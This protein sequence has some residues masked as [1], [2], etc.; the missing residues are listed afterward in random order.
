MNRPHTRNTC[1]ERIFNE[2]SIFDAIMQKTIL[3]HGALGS[4]SDLTPLA[5]ALLRR[6][7][8]PL[9]F[10]FSGHGKTPFS[11][12]FEITQFCTELENFISM[13]DLRPATI[14]GYSM[15]GYVALCS[16]LRNTEQI[17]RV[18]T[19]GTKFDWS[20][21]SVAKE[22]R[23]LDPELT[24]QKV[25]AFAAMLHQKHGDNW[26][27]LMRATAEM[28]RKIS[29]DNTLHPEALKRISQKVMI[30]LADHDQMVSSEE[31]IAVYRQLP[32]ATMYMLP[33]TKH[34]LE[35]ADPDLLA[36]IIIRQSGK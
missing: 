29:S 35:T 13:N 28:M 23:M 7:I 8:T 17:A 6:N 11:D 32:D 25:P 10:S 22:T 4:E 21:A 20:E 1:T 31:T 5:G 14:F 24:Q 9:S 15:G 16:A 2:Y 27:D 36:E 19:L 30:G 26:K 34:Q 12:R 18:I 3:L 33:G